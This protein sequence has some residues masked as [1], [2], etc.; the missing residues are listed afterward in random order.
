MTVKSNLFVALHPKHRIDG[1]LG[2]K[3]RM[4]WMQR[5]R[6]RRGQ[7]TSRTDTN[8]RDKQ[9]ANKSN[10]IPALNSSS[11]ATVRLVQPRPSIAPTPNLVPARQLTRFRE[12]LQR[13]RVKPFA[14]R[15]RLGFGRHRV[16]AFEGRV[17]TQHRA[18][19]WAHGGVES[20]AEKVGDREPAVVSVFGD[21]ARADAVHRRF[22][23]ARGPVL[24]QIAEVADHAAGDGGDIGPSGFFGFVGVP[25]WE[26][27]LEAAGGVLEEAGYGAPT[28]RPKR[29]SDERGTARRA[30]E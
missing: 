13:T 21:R 8:T 1:G 6:S 2:W 20:G 24:D 25:G 17:F 9:P 28:D 18:R 3:P 5:F 23:E 11:T 12:T 4:T 7:V 10:H 26:P 16:G 14:C 19:D 22:Q 15:Q 29:G 27:D 30:S